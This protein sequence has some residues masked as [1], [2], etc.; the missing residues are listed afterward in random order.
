LCFF[1]C[2]TGGVQCK[3]DF[4]VQ[5]TQDDDCCSDNC[6]GGVCADTVTEC[7]GVTCAKVSKG[8]CGA[9][10][11]DD[12]A[13]CC[14]TGA[15]CQ[16]NQCICDAQQCAGCCE[17]GP[18]NPGFCLEN[19][20]PQ[21]GIAGA[22]CQSCPEGCCDVG[23]NCQSGNTIENCAA[24]SGICQTCND[25]FEVCAGEQC[26]LCEHDCACQGQ[27]VCDGTTIAPNTDCGTNRIGRP[28]R[29]MVRTNLE[30][31]CIVEP[32]LVPCTATCVGDEECQL[33]YGSLAMC[34][35][36]GSRCDL[37]PGTATNFCALP[38]EK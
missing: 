36:G 4:G 14:G 10:C 27:S 8:C 17:N 28:C 13:N 23:G 22:L 33:C 18:N 16:N 32:F 3:S 9:T 15:I 20:P 24:A 30:P 26:V 34:V 11:C 35:T 38:C 7:E 12:A 31:V 37:I 21:C 19:V 29:C 5:C 25:R 6:F 1:G 2:G